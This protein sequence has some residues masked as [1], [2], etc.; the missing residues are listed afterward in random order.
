MKKDSSQLSFLHYME[1]DTVEQDWVAP[2]IFPDVSQAKYVAVDLETCDPNLLTK[3]PGWVRNDGFI[4]GVAIAFGD[5]YA[6]YPIKH[7]AGGNLTQNAVMKWLKKQMATPNVAKVFHNALY[8]LGWLKW[9]GVE[10]QGK[11]ID[12]MIAAPLL[13]ENRFS[14]SLNNLGRDYLNDRKNEKELRAAAKDWGIDPKAELWK[15]P[16][17]YVGRYAEQDAALTLKLWK[18]FETEIEKNSLMDV[19]ELESSLIPLLLNMRE[20][21]VRVDVDKAEETKKQLAVKEQGLL[22]EIYKDTGVLVEPWVATSVASVLDHYKIRYTKTEKS[23][24]PSITKSFLQTCS[25]EVA[26]KILKL[27]ELNKANSTF[28]DSIFKHQH[29]GRI[30]CEFNQLRS[31][32]AGT[33]TG[34]FSSSNPNLQQIPARDP[35]LKKAIR[36][37]FLPE[38]G[39]LWGSFDY[40][41]QEPRLLVHY[42]ALLARK[43]EDPRVE[44]IVAAY[45]REDVDFHQIVADMAG[46]GRKEAKTVNLGIMYGMGRGKLANTLDISQEQAKDL[47]DNYHSKVPFVKRI[48]DMATKQAAQY[49][50]IRTLLGRKC[51]FD[52]W[53]PNSFGYNKPMKHEDA[54][55]EYGPG[56]RRAFTYKALNKL[57]QGSA[58]DQTKKAMAECYKEGL[59][60][61]LTVHDELCFSISSEEQASRIKEIMETCVDLRVPSKVDQELGDNWGEVG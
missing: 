12:T 22:D 19:F 10:V 49:G 30:H 24:Q 18:L 59:M 42:S 35:D 9:A 57:I 20:K 53:E 5:F 4:V 45:N 48:A 44:E 14:Y 3:G 27:R 6:Y 29:N 56:I 50:Q 41:S 23:Q 54:I 28:I 34:R 38:D 58:A 40:S 7:Q 26:T 43:Y 2:E 55:K 21:G 47:L 11:I 1:L 52:L 31:D 36:G 33:V 37:L 61:L 32:D 8:D 51:R 13:D 16:A 17:R 25:H 15:L 60:P 39:E 46:I